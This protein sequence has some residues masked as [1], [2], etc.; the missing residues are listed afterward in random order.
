L[1]SING[2][3]RAADTARRAEDAGVSFFP[4]LVESVRN[5]FVKRCSQLRDGEIRVEA[6]AR[7]HT[8]ASIAAYCGLALLLTSLVRCI[9]HSTLQVARGGVAARPHLSGIGQARYHCRQNSPCKPRIEDYACLGRAS[10]KPLA[11]PRA[12]ASLCHWH[13]NTAGLVDLRGL[14][15][16]EHHL[17]ELGRK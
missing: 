3:A 1:P 9:I 14:R 6:C 16:D 11:P 15:L 8:A 2:P 13:R 7:G 10:L 4:K 12:V 5:R 17:D